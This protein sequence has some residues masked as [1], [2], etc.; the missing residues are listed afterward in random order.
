[1][2]N[3]QK[4][5]VRYIKIHQVQPGRYIKIQQQTTNKSE[6]KR[7][8]ACKPHW[9]NQK[10]MTLKIHRCKAAAAALNE[11]AWVKDGALA[12]SKSDEPYIDLITDLLHFADSQGLNTEDILSAATN[13]MNQERLKLLE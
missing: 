9:L 8:A 4:Q 13:H 5:P 7:G 12:D 3:H 6:I 11:H 10:Q 2:T 1:M